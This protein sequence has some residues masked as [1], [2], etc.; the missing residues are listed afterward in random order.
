MVPDCLSIQVCDLT[1]VL[2]R[3]AIFNGINLSFEG[4]AIHGLL[5]QNG[6]GKTTLLRLIGGVC[7]PTEGKILMNGESTD[8]RSPHDAVARGVRMSYQE[9]TCLRDLTI[10]ENM[11]FGQYACGSG[12]SMLSRKKL[13]AQAQQILDEMEM[14]FKADQS[15]SS[16]NYGKMQMLKIACLLTGD[17]PVRVLLMDEPYRT[18][19]YQEYESLYRVLR[20]L[21]ERGITILFST[22]RVEDAL[23]VCDTITILRQNGDS[24]QL[25]TSG[26]TREEII[27]KLSDRKFR[28][29]T[30]P[31]IEAQ[32]GPVVLEMDN[33]STCRIEN[34]SLRIRKG[35]IVGIAGLLGSGRTGVARALAGQD[36]ILAGS[37]RLNKEV[38]TSP[39]RPGEVGVLLCNRRG[40]LLWDM[41]IARNITVARLSQ[42][43]GR[44]FLSGS[45]ERKIGF[46][47]CRQFNIKA[48][49]S[50]DTART[51]SAGN[52]QKLL[53]AR[54]FFSN[55]RILVLDEPT[56]NIDVVSRN[57]I[58][59]LMN[60]YI[61][62]GNSIILISSD[63][64]EL[65]GMS[66]RI[67]VM[68]DRT[69]LSEI[70]PGQLSYKSLIANT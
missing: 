50:D 20:R 12:L 64:D 59:N 36:P 15:A 49:N 4:G 38:L 41:T 44:A 40:L 7:T 8:F 26:L 1:Y 66:H 45:A 13:Q 65:A 61:C 24:E 70:P 69:V 19:S 68:K 53:L 47:Y 18:C 9:D 32:P 39:A 16:L 67:I 5:G 11:M 57:E 63:L 62:Q 2:D 27:S 43:S 48:R 28:H 34:V 54:L 6:T 52:Q 23:A 60:S 21:K 58:Y 22:H 42:I 31:R 30:Y 51:L 46:D 55:C 25:S 37:M 10:A 29:L 17:T 33:L 35:E 56:M 3:Y 14:P